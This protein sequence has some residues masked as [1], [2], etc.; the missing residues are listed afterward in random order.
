MVGFTP[1]YCTSH[2]LIH[3]VSAVPSSSCIP[4]VCSYVSQLHASRC[5]NESVHVPATADSFDLVFAS[6]FLHKLHGNDL[7]IMTS[8]VHDTVPDSPTVSF[9]MSSMTWLVW[10]EWHALT[11]CVTLTAHHLHGADRTRVEAIWAFAV[12]RA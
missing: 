9:V 3:T 2:I 12:S 5:F 4:A 10:R 11:L 1:P 6:M 7:Q 8:E